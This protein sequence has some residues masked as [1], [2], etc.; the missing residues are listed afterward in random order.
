MIHKLGGPALIKF[1]TS[2]NLNNSNDVKN[3]NDQID[4][5]LNACT[6]IIKII[7]RIVQVN[8]MEIGGKFR[9]KTNVW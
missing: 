4:A 9:K 1:L 5:L 3:I 7:I 8:H 6:T 2:S